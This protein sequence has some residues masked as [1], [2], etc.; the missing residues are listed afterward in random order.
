MDDDTEF[1]VTDLR[2]GANPTNAPSRGSDV[3][4]GSGGDVDGA[5]R[6]AALFRRRLTR[7]QRLRRVGVM[8]GAML[9]V[10]A[11]VLVGIP[12]ASGIVS[13]WLPATPTARAGTN[14]IFA[15]RG[16]PWGH[17]T[18]DGRPTAYTSQGQP[19]AL[20]LPRGSHTLRYVAPPFPDLTCVVSV[21]SAVSDTCPLLNG[22]P[23]Q[24]GGSAGYV[25][26]IDLGAI[27]GRLAA[28]AYA[29]LVGAVAGSLNAADAVRP[30]LPGDRYLGANDTILTAATTLQAELHYTLNADA[31]VSVPVGDGESCVILCDDP[32]GAQDQAEAPT[33]I[34]GANARVDWRYTPAAGASADLPVV[35]SGGPSGDANVL[36]DLAVRWQNGWQVE[37]LAG[38]R[39]RDL[40]ALASAWL[41][42]QRP[43]QPTPTYTVSGSAQAATDPLGG[44][45][46]TVQFEENGHPVGK[47]GHFLYSFGLILA[48]NDA[49]HQ[50]DPGLPVATATE[51]ARASQL[52]GA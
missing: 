15:A 34:L 11:A 7:R 28:P 29:S 26:T 51:A 45:L 27:P 42:S 17:L 46:V 8:G 19:L 24:D 18:L 39:A 5:R 21:P 41:Y 48:A 13:G 22:L 4:A 16:V 52:A 20:F 35:P 30:V 36:M 10:L 14:V 32:F 6:G 2:A 12:Q 23:G 47:A 40:C 31:G 43:L 9:V 38:G 44:C 25:R 1:E 3:A 33:W 50:M 37:P 49:A